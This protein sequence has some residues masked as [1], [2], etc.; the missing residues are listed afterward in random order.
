MKGIRRAGIVIMCAVFMMGAMQVLA[1]SKETSEEKI[2]EGVFIDS[3]DVSKMTY[4]EAKKAVKKLV[5]SRS[6]EEVKITVNKDVV[7]T[8]MKELGYQWANDSILEEAV[9]LGKSGNVIKR[10]KEDLEL[11]NEGMKYEV[12][13]ELNRETLEEKLQELCEPYNIEAK[14]ASIKLTSTGFVTVPEKEGCV[15]DYKAT[16]ETFYKYITEKWDGK[17][18]IEFVAETEV[19][20]PKYTAEDCEKV[21]STPMGSFTTNFTVGSAYNNRNLNIKNGADKID[22]NIL[23]PGEQFSCNEHLAPWT[24]DNGWY[25]AGTYVDG[26]VA[27]S[28]GGGI[29]Q[30]SSTLYNALLNAEIKVVERFSHSMAV[31]YVDLAADAALAGDYKDLVFENDTDAPIYVQGIYNSGGS[32]TFNIYGHDTRDANHSVKYISE[33]VSTTPIKT[34]T[35]KDS[36]KPA[37]Y[38][39]VTENGHVGYVAKLWK[40]TYENGKE[41]KKELLH[42][43]RY[44]MAPK[45]V[46]KGTGG[47]KTTEDKETTKT[48]D[49]KTK[50]EETTKKES[51]KKDDSKKSSDEE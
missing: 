25:P 11:K 9:S 1:A 22:G 29:C 40:V 50:N 43:S 51:K 47:S 32:I 12:Q 44:A 16:T 3:V 19:A 46:V 49:K 37:G 41:V 33:T 30:V 8:T 10:Y 45:K 20:K 28:L 23:Y 31:S 6:S 15:V 24:E 34:E 39:E 27:D 26:G 38:Y 13:M 5:D 17:S 7:T 35:K 14:N 21:S 18:D 2:K 48:S 42:T 4:D 36:S